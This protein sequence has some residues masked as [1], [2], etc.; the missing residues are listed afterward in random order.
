MTDASNMPGGH[1]ERLLVP[2]TAEKL[3]RYCVTRMAG[4]PVT[5]SGARTGTV[6]GA[7]PFGGWVISLERLNAIKSIDKEGR[8]AVVERAS[9]WPTLRKRSRPMGCLYPPDPTE[10]S[11]QI[12]GTV[13]TNAPAPEALGTGATRIHC[14]V[15]GRAGG[16]RCSE[17]STRR[18]VFRRRRPHRIIDSFRTKDRG[19][20]A[21]TPARMCGRM[22]GY[23]NER[24]MDAID[25]FIGSE[26]TLGV[27]VEIELGLMAKPE[28]FFSGIVFFERHEDLLAFVDELK[29]ISFASRKCGQE[30]PLSID[31]ALIEY[32]DGRA[33]S[34]YTKSF[35]KR[36]TGWQERS[37]SSRRRRL[38]RGSF[39]GRVER[40]ARKAQ[41]RS[42]PFMVH[43]D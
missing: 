26:G 5:V 30:C 34:L 15:D 28:G 29:E 38:K 43:D 2:E 33:L 42:R 32:F 20:S 27:I 41:R 23:F 11:L 17:N 16:W 25:L 13:A 14:W 3:P 18:G 39:D 21:H 4:I 24:P 37:F 31:A 8:R 1:A 35:P 7:V 19:E 36:R 9:S 12:G 40:S 10:W 22:S 6:G